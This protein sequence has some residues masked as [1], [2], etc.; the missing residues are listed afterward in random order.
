MNADGDTAPLRDKVLPSDGL[1]A[2]SKC[3]SRFG[4][5]PP[6][7]FPP[8]LYL[9]QRAPNEIDAAPCISMWRDV[10][11]R[12]TEVGTPEVLTHQSNVRAL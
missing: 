5:L 9:V 11:T 7:S 1:N 12:V 2:A 3:A 10:P 6:I 4:G 8:K